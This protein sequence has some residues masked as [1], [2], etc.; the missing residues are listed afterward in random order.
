LRELAAGL[1]VEW[2]GE[3]ADMPTFLGGLD[4]FAM[5][6]EPAGC[7]NAI[8]EASA[9]GLP[10]IATDHGGA[11]ELVIESV[12]GRICPRGDPQSFAEAL[13]ALAHGPKR[14]EEMGRAARIHMEKEFA[15]SKMADLYRA[16]I[17]DVTKVPCSR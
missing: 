1:P 7:P 12:T 3:V 5:I 17:G 13:L 4:I 15:I 11:R 16:L 8:L 14:R 6:S 2:M 10:V 9:A